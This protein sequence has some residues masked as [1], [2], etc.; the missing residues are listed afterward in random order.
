MVT[1]SEGSGALGVI[2]GVMLVLGHTAVPLITLRVFRLWPGGKLA[3]KTN[4][5]TA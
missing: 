1:L 3:A 4:A 5:A 2:A